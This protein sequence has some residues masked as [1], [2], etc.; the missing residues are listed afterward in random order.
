MENLG[1]IY[2]VIWI[3]NAVFYNKPPIFVSILLVATFKYCMNTV[4]ILVGL[5]SWILQLSRLEMM[6]FILFY[7]KE[8]GLTME[9]YLQYIRIL[10][11]NLKIIII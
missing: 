7:N 2:D 8:N 11:F 6:T 1:D 9:E 3:N 5:T 4:I 10:M